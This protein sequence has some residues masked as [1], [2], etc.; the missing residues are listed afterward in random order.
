MSGDIP[1][2]QPYT[3]SSEHRNAERCLFSFKVLHRSRRIVCCLP[4]FCSTGLINKVRNFQVFITHHLIN[5]PYLPWPCVFC[6]KDTIQAR[7]AIECSH[8]MHNYTKISIHLASQN[9]PYHRM[10]YLFDNLHEKYEH[11]VFIQNNNAWH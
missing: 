11:L 9:L 3:P 1:T 10:Y 5:G 6:Q 8:C 7:R 4:C 2:V